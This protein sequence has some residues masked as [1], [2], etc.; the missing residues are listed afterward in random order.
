MKE[1]DIGFSLVFKVREDSQICIFYLYF[2][3]IREIGT[4]WAIIGLS[5]IICLINLEHLFRK[6]QLLPCLTKFLL[7][8]CK[9]LWCLQSNWRDNQSDID[10]SIQIS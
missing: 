1:V 6:H 5:L 3:G 4:K 8:L 10:T 9:A 7:G 2:F